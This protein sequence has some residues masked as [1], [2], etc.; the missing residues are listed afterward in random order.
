MHAI[1]LVAKIHKPTLRA[2]AYAEPPGRRPSRPLTVE[3]SP[4]DSEAIIEGVGAPGDPGEPEGARES[5]SA[6]SQKPV[7]DYVRNFRR[8][9]PRDLV[10]VYVP[11]VRGG[12]LVGA[13]PAQPERPA[14]QRAVCSSP[15]V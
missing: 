2:L 9:S 6:R 5:P 8:A 12:P 14:A 7:V 13:P 3:V 10:T 11:G 15:P 4:G 1:V